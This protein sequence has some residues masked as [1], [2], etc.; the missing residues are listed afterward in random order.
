MLKVIST[1]HRPALPLTKSN[2]QRFATKYIL[3]ACHNAYQECQIENATKYI[4]TMVATWSYT[5]LMQ[6]IVY[7]V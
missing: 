3:Q 7:D 2:S 4:L 1:Q 5:I 6:R